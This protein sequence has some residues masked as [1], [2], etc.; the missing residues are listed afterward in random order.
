MGIKQGLNADLMSYIKINSLHCGSLKKNDN[1]KYPSD[2]Q[3][4]NNN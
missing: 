1:F 4:F 2:N 3:A